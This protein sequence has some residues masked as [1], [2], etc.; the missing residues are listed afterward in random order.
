MLKQVII[1]SDSLM[2]VDAISSNSP[3]GELQPIVQ[4]IF[5]LSSFFDVWKVK[6]LKR[7][8]NKVAHEL[9]KLA[10]ETR[11]SQT[12]VEMEPPMVQQLCQIDRAKC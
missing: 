11:M 5:L 10:R 8:Y 12:W 7:E 3:H 6:H 4:G 1:E 2:I 9:A